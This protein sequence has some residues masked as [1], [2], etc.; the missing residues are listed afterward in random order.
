MLMAALATATAASQPGREEAGDG[1]GK[2]EE[3]G[4]ST[5][6]FSLPIAMP[7][8]PVVPC[9]CSLTL[10]CLLPLPSLP[11][12]AFLA[13]AGLPP[14]PSLGRPSQYTHPVLGSAQPIIR[15]SWTL[16]A[17]ACGSGR[18]SVL[19]ALFLFSFVSHR[20]V[21]KWPWPAMP[22]WVTRQRSA[23]LGGR[24]VP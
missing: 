13:T 2:R 10:P 17:T 21:G 15:D 8:M 12:L 1:R 23:V 24:V 16:A 20:P 11:P 4:P 5:M 7:C 22:T 3:V 14:S 6:P 18:G 9:Q 19:L